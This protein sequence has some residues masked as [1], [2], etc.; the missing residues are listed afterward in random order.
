[1][2]SHICRKISELIRIHDILSPWSLQPPYAL[3]IVFIC[4]HWWC[5]WWAQPKF[6]VF[7]QRPWGH[8]P[9]CFCAT[10]CKLYNL[11]D[12]NIII[13]RWASQTFPEVWRFDGWDERACFSVDTRASLQYM[14]PSLFVNVSITLIKGDSLW[15]GGRRSAHWGWIARG[16][17]EPSRKCTPVIP[18][19]GRLKQEDFNFEAP[20]QKFVS[21]IREKKPKTKT[22]GREREEGRA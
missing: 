17:F 21:K 3:L 14:V 13:I 11:F 6:K 16:G 10:F 15:T 12:F 18:A 2:S 1:M 5:C 7:G 20:D 9:L 8:I 4:Y 19:H 22:K